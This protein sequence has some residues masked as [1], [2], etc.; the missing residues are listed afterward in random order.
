MCSAFLPFM[1]HSTRART[2]S[3]QVASNSK[4]FTAMVALQM[5]Q[6]GLLDIDAPA[7]DANPK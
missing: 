1:L 2:R 6:E 5:Q 4:A 3:S 7:R